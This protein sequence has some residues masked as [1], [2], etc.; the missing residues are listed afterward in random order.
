MEAEIGRSCDDVASL[1]VALAER[2]HDVAGLFP[3]TFDVPGSAAY[4][5]LRGLETPRHRDAT[6]LAQ[7][8]LCLAARKARHEDAAISLA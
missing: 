8:V 7:D 1:Q 6:N 2:L 3:E 5:G 4:V